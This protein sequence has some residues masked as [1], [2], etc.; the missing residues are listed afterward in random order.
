MTTTTR[1]RARRRIHFCTK[2]EKRIES[3][4]AAVEQGALEPAAQKTWSCLRLRQCGTG[5]QWVDSHAGERRVTQKSVME[6]PR[7]LMASG[8][9]WVL[10]SA[11]I[12]GLASVATTVIYFTPVPGQFLFYCLAYGNTN[13]RVVL[14]RLNCCDSEHE[15]DFLSLLRALLLAHEHRSSHALTFCFDWIAFYY[16]RK[17]N[18]H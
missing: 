6:K 8:G 1:A 12:I 16:T 4:L 9:R 17:T 14:R 18:W 15:I 11:L 2:R 10:R 13:K 7:S 3:E 5:A